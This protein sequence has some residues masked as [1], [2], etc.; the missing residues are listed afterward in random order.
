MKTN[1]SRVHADPTAVWAVIVAAI[2][3][4]AAT[5]LPALGVGEPIGSQSDEV[6]SLV[7]PAGWAFSIWGPLFAGSI[8][9][10]IYQALPAQRTSQLLAQ[11]R[12]PAAGAFLGN[13][14]WALYAQ[15]FGL[16][17]ISSLIIIFTLVCLIG[18]YRVFTNWQPVFSRGQRWLAILPLSALAAWLTA[19]TIVNIVASLRYHGVD[20]GESGPLVAAIV[21]IIGGVI[22]SLALARGRGNPPYAVVFL[23][24]LAAIFSAGGQRAELVAGAAVIAASLVIIGTF[25]GLRS[26]GLARWFGSASPNT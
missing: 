6:R 1:N 18:A 16:S 4:I 21:V 22:T 20:A 3:Q 10:A 2:L 12:L 23:W 26:A 24:A 17:A 8:A 25:V 11:I 19:A 15:F 9:F 14:V 13:A 7:T 5:S